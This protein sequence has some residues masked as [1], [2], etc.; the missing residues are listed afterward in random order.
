MTTYPL[1]R[2]VGVSGPNPEANLT[3]ALDLAHARRPATV[4]VSPETA[5][6]TP[7][8]EGVTLIACRLRRDTDYGVV[9]DGSDADPKVRA[10]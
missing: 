8:R 9:I 4:Y 5:A 10:A 6:K 3:R 7:A 1:M 2:L